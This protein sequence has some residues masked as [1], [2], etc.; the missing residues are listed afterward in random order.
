MLW[1]NCCSTNRIIT[2]CLYKFN[3][4]WKIWGHQR[5]LLVHILIIKKI[6][7]VTARCRIKIMDI[8]LQLVLKNN[9]W[10]G[11]L[12]KTVNQVLINFWCKI[13]AQ[14][15]NNLTSHL[16]NKVVNSKPVKKET[17]EVSP[18]T[19]PTRQIKPKMKK[20]DK[21]V[22]NIFFLYKLLKKL[23]LKLKNKF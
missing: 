8:R 10:L 11:R 4:K 19:R 1:T 9:N 6:K 13:L 23:T 7:M 3:N 2:L 12:T 21:N 14:F 17:K 20:I 5:I 16:S 15:T 22:I 18:Q